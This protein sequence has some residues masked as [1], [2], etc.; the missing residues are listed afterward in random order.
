MQKLFTKQHGPGEE[1]I[2][3]N[4]SIR[5]LG[6]ELTLEHAYRHLRCSF[7]NADNIDLFRV[8]VEEPTESPIDR[9]ESRL[10]FRPRSRRPVSYGQDTHVQKGLW[11]RLHERL[12]AP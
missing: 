12:R 8:P 2:L 4:S 3:K 1:D 10:L 6:K 5:F 11:P 9:T 7:L